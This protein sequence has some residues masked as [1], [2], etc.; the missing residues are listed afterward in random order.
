MRVGS[1]TPEQ[2]TIAP[3][4][5]FLLV[6]PRMQVGD[7]YIIP[8]RAHAA[9]NDVT[10]YVAIYIRI[11]VAIYIRSCSYIHTYSCSYIHT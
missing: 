11:A 7:I 1:V 9:Q 3:L 5:Q 6:G 10:I 8:D 4:L 2:L